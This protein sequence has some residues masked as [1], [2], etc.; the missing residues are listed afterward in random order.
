MTPSHI[1]RRTPRGIALCIGIGLLAGLLSGLFGVGG[2]TVVVPLLVLLLGFDQRL[3]AGTSLA[4]IVPTAAVGVISYGLNDAV[5]WIPALLLAVG[6]VGGAQIGTWLLPKVSQTILRWIFVGFLVIVIVSLFVVIPSRD[7]Q[8][9]LMWGNGIALVVLGLATGTVSGLIGVGG[10]IIVVPALM[11]VFGT[12]DLVAKGTSLLMMI[13]AAISGTIGNLRR[14]NVDLVA[15]ASVGLAAC[16]TTALG[17]WLATVVDPF[18]GNVLFA[19]FLVFIGAQM[20]VK[21]VRA[22]RTR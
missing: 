1:A 7:A 11:M 8:L 12:S 18:A 13:P 19:I 14:G 21:A 16:T 9:E 3:A 20:A 4:A 15:A 22:R 6:A 2:G 10:G 5:A 17:A